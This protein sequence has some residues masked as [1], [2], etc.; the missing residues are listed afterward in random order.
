MPLYKLSSGSQTQCWAGGKQALYRLMQ[1]INSSGGRE[2]SEAGGAC[3]SG[4]MS[5][6]LANVWNSSSEESSP[7]VSVSTSLSVWNSSLSELVME[8]T[9]CSV[10]NWSSDSES[11]TTVLSVTDSKGREKSDLAV[12]YDGTD[13]RV[14]TLLAPGQSRHSEATCPSVSSSS[15]SSSTSSTFRLA[16]QSS[17]T[18]S[19]HLIWE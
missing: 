18:L 15:A 2:R 6:T 7:P 19:R 8:R 14:E 10:W 11:D 12:L 9:L 13:V 5:L 4:E 3:L 17:N 16:E 1:V